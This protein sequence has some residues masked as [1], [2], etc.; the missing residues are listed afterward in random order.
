MPCLTLSC[1]LTGRILLAQNG[2]VNTIFREFLTVGFAS[3]LK[4]VKNTHKINEKPA[5][6]S[7]MKN[8]TRSDSSEASRRILEDE[9][10]LLKKRLREIIGNESV[11]AFSRKCGV[12]ES[13][14]RKYL[15]GTLPSSK[16]TAVMA[17]AGGVTVD[18]LATGRLPKRRADLK[19]VDEAPDPLNPERLR[20]ALILAEDSARVQPLSAE[21]RADMVLAFY[22]RLNKGNSQ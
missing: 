5:V 11:S 17:D 21:Q 19:S 10:D 20:M 2:E 13:L 14:L 9:S 1:F 3:D 4:A 15:D 18:W 6:Y 16:N 12:G 7:E 22:N 8:P